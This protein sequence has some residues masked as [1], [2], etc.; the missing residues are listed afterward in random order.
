MA[1]KDDESGQQFCI[2]GAR[3]ISRVY[4]RFRAEMDAVREGRDPEAIHRMRVASRRLRAGLP[5]FSRCYSQRTYQRIS[6]GIRRITKDLG[7]ARDL[8]VQI[9][10]LEEILGDRKD[11]DEGEIK[12]VNI[13]LARIR[14]RR[15]SLQPKVIADCTRLE[16]KGVP[17][18]LE[19][20]MRAWKRGS[21]P[22]RDS[23]ATGM[24]PMRR[25]RKAI[26]RRIDA[27]TAYS[28][29]VHDPCAVEAHH[30]MRIAA[31]KLR[32][33]LEVYSPL[34]GKENKPAIRRLKKIQEILGTLHDCDVW[35]T[36]LGSAL[37]KRKGKTGGGSRALAQGMAYV[38]SD[39]K[40]AREA[41]YRLLVKEW[42]SIEG[43]GVF[44]RLRENVREG[45]GSAGASLSPGDRKV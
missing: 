35:I 11:M 4:T 23:P 18:L 43:S 1:R 12:G 44:S 9:N 41:Y 19:S 36:D 30:A 7:K 26:E 17:D 27:L 39:R 8:D 40:R 29:M 34:F 25:A 21:A 38:F 15:E 22:S 5:V 16:K 33:L 3:Y 2:Y 24:F 42:E 6:G 13:L 28:P 14:K 45:P 37:E 10:Y 20:S 31:K 32:Y